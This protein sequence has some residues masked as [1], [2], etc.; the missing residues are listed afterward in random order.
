VF[1]RDQGLFPDVKIPRI[2]MTVKSN[3]RD[4]WL[5]EQQEAEFLA[6]AAKTS[7]ARMSRLHRF[8][9]VA[10]NT[11]AR[12]GSIER[13]WWEQVDFQAGI[14]DFRSGTTSSKRRVPVPI[15]DRLRPDLERAYA[16]RTSP[17]VLDATGD[18]RHQWVAWIKT[19]PF[20]H[21]RPHDLR[22]TWATLAARAGVSL[23]DIAGV[24][25]D[26]ISVVTTHYAHH[27]PDHLRGAV[28]RRPPQK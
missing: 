7:G 2:K 20:P 15:S 27:T 12:R 19:T 24:L 10:L 4:V 1:A 26:T 28:N 9:V 6:L 25:G 5:T 13:L 23:W 22:R 3:P 11:A 17:Y 8:V 18:L 21:L 16:E 14:I